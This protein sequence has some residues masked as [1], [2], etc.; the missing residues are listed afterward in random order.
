MNEIL[1]TVLDCSGLSSL[2][3]VNK[4]SLRVV[5]YR[6]PLLL[7]GLTLYSLTLKILC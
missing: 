7:L 2:F 5:V 6:Y 4:D 1:F 3:E